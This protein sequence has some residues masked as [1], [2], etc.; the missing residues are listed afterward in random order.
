MGVEDD[1][2]CDTFGGLR[3]RTTPDLS[4]KGDRLYKGHNQ[5]VI[6]PTPDLSK[7]GD[8]FYKG[9][10]KQRCLRRATPMHPHLSSVQG[11]IDRTYPP[12]VRV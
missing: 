7:R 5:S 9:H 2:I 4:T 10:T 6:A 1:G 3:Q 12:K 8:R 11:A